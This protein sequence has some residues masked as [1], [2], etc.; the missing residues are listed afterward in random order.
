MGA[1]H[2]IFWAIATYFGLRFLHRG[3]RHLSGKPAG[4]R[5][6]VVVFLLVMLQMSTAIRPIVG[7]SDRFL[8][9][10]KK[11]FIKHWME[12]MEAGQPVAPAAR[13]TARNP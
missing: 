9:D 5:L 8:T 4:L 2:L 10:E 3:L 11:F 1:L 13:P 12:Q 6:W 7:K